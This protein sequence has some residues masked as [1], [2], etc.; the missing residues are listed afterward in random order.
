[1]GEECRVCNEFS[2]KCI[3]IIISDKWKFSGMNGW[4]LFK[5]V[6]LLCTL[7]IQLC[8]ISYICTRIFQ[9]EGDTD[10]QWYAKLL[11]YLHSAV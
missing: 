4:C 11:Q 7:I 5:L 10:N 8:Y 3:I 1:M 6:A 2:V 9:V